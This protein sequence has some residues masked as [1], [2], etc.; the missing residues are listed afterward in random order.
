[1]RLKETKSGLGFAGQIITMDFKALQQWAQKE[2]SPKQKA[3]EIFVKYASNNM[4]T[5]RIS[6]TLS[7]YSLKHR[8]EELSRELQKI[9]PNYSYEY[10]GNEDFIIA[11]L[12]AGFN[13]K[14]N[15]RTSP[16]YYFNLGK[17]DHKNKWLTEMVNE[18]KKEM[19]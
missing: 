4:V 10:I 5:T 15:N 13:C 2:P 6:N 17:L 1:M 7:S 18:Y 16:N 8:V 19:K 12:Q 3:L 11:M 9:D 14:K